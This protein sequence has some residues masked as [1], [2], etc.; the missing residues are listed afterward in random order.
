MAAIELESSTI[1]A[2]YAAYENRQRED[3]REYLGMSSL[4]NECERQL[5]YE[6]RWCHPP[7]KFDGRKLRLFETGHREEARLIADLRAAGVYVINEEGGKQIAVEGVGGH[8]RGHLDGTARG[9]PEAP[10]TEHVLECKTHNLKSFKTLLKDGVEKSK[11]VHAAQMQLYMHFTGLF[12]ALYL[13]VCKDDESIYSERINYDPIAAARLIA[14]AERIIKH[15]VPPPKL[16]EDPSAKLAFACGWCPAKGICHEREFALRN[17][18]T[19]IHSTPVMNDGKWWCEY[20]NHEITTD[21]Q[22]VGCLHHNYI[23]PLVP[24]EQVD[25]TEETIIYKKP[26]GELWVDGGES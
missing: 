19:C 11:P 26:D 12:R 2:I 14:K 16:H 4:G 21:E 15:Q 7:E 17:C 22:R 5:W 20:H 18:R 9:I 13:A 1:S 23:P 3:R 25:H 10:K 6:W 24:Y 8:L